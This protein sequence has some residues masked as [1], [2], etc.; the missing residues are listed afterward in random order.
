MSDDAIIDIDP[1]IAA[2]LRES[3]A[4]GRSGAC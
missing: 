3:A 1:E 2:V 4:A